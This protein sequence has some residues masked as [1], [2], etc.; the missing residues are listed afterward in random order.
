MEEPFIKRIQFL[1]LF[2]NSYNRWSRIKLRR[3]G[4]WTH[5][6][7]MLGRPRP[8]SRTAWLRTLSL[9]H[10]HK[11]RPGLIPLVHVHWLLRLLFAL[12]HAL[13]TFA[14]FFPFVG[15]SLTVFTLAWQSRTPP[16]LLKK[17]PGWKKVRLGAPSICSLEKCYFNFCGPIQFA[18]FTSKPTSKNMHWVG[19]QRTFAGVWGHLFYYQFILALVILMD[20]KVVNIGR[21]VDIAV[22]YHC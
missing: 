1:S 16:F 14:A 4:N 6:W 13:Q 2:K 10:S 7:V 8:E 12:P 22:G 20:T 17:E 3:S 11:G 21:Y 15:R 18:S 9:A 19:P 5:R